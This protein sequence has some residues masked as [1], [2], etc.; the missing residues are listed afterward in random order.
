MASTPIGVLE[1]TGT[2]STRA[3]PDTESAPH[4]LHV[5][6]RPDAQ[7][8]H[9]VTF[10]H[11]AQ[12]NLVIGSFFRDERQATLFERKADGRVVLSFRRAPI[13]PVRPNVPPA[14][15]R[16][17]RAERRCIPWAKAQEAFAA[18]EE[19]GL[20]AANFVFEAVNDQTEYPGMAPRD[21]Y[22]P[23]AYRPETPPRGPRK[24]HKA[25][26]RSRGLPSTKTEAR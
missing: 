10:V 1:S 6:R 25:V 3:T 5:S 20:V 21:S 11:P 14:F 22:N 19:Q 7:G 18:M 8:S 16:R 13:G 2:L 4:S 23:P 15:D 17:T 24:V 12:K 9:Q 26:P